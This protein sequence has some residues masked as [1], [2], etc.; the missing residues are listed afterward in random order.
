MLDEVRCACGAAHFRIVIGSK[1]IDPVTVPFAGDR[2]CRRFCGF[3][4]RPVSIETEQAADCALCRQQRI[5]T[6]TLRCQCGR[7]WEIVDGIPEF[8]T[9]RLPQQLAGQDRVVETD[10]RTDPRW[11]PF[12]VAHPNGSVYH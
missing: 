8:S 10:P 4:Q 11:E 9:K 2:T 3:R 7:Q 12:V 5:V 1:T 6:G